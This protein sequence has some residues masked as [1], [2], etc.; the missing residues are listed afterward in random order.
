[1]GSSLSSKLEIISRSFA[2]LI[3]SVY[4]AG[5]LVASIY[6]AEYGATPTSLFRPR[7]MGAG[8]LF[9][10][11]VALPAPTGIYA[12]RFSAERWTD[13]Q[14]Q[15]KASSKVHVF[16][17]VHFAAFLYVSSVVLAAIMSGFLWDRAVFNW[18][19]FVIAATYLV[20]MGGIVYAH[21]FAP[22]TGR[23]ALLSLLCA[24]LLFAVLGEFAGQGFQILVLWVAGAGAVADDVARHWPS[25]K[26]L[27]GHRP[28]FLFV[29]LMAAA[30]FFARAIYPRIRP[31]YGGG[32]PSPAV[33]QFNNVPPFD[34]PDRSSVWLLEES[35]DGYYVLR[36][37]GST[38][39]V[40]LPKKIIRGIYFGAATEKSGQ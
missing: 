22:V 28:E 13:S 38:K 36:S 19:F 10:L 24:V 4:A 5:F 33:I 27:E 34:M 1:V 40:F 3:G 11:F 8:V 32:D 7:F 26:Q 30:T 29:T 6:L 18:H 9:W 15:A 2:V 14:S 35:E 31:E 25:M 17:S 16:S 12:R 20:A 21:T 39:A 37:K 23:G